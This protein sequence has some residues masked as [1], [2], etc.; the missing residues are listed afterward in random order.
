M[1]IPCG[2]LS[3]GG[4][5]KQYARNSDNSRDHM[6]HSYGRSV[7]QETAPQGRARRMTY[8]QAA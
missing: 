1:C 7:P 3:H 5:M 6:A 2:L 8:S 4:E